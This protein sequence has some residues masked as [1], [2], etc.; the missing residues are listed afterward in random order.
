VRGTLRGGDAMANRDGICRA[1]LKT[2]NVRNGVGLLHLNRIR[3]QA[4]TG[5]EVG[6]VSPYVVTAARR[7][8][9]LTQEDPAME[10]AFG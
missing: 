5:S 1:A 8:S 4:G 6:A 7:C 2:E 9:D 3:A 10:S